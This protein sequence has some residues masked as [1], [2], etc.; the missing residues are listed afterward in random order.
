MRF[1][2]SWQ[3]SRARQ[4]DDDR[5]LRA[6]RRGR[7]G[8]FDHGPPKAHHPPFV[9]RIAVEDT[10]RFQQNW[11][12]PRRRATALRE[13]RCT[14]D[15]YGDRDEQEKS[16]RRLHAGS[17]TLVS[18]LYHG[19]HG[20]RCQLDTVTTLVVNVTSLVVVWRG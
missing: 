12:R 7:T 18:R 19:G 8:R 20:G 11:R 2:Q 14:G 16:H 9:D 6:D 5:V 17:V 13:R 4:I 15:R 1:D 10:G 3:Q